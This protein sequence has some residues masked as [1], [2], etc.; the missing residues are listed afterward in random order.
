MC[1]V[2]VLRAISSRRIDLPAARSGFCGSGYENSSEIIGER[3]E[4]VR[5]PSDLNWTDNY[6]VAKIKMKSV[7]DHQ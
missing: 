1:S 2:L 3:S 7:T 5:N 6:D 4:S